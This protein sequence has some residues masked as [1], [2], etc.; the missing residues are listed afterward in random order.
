MTQPEVLTQWFFLPRTCT[1]YFDRARVVSTV[2][3]VCIFIV[4]CHNLWT[5]LSLLLKPLCAKPRSWHR[6]CRILWSSQT[7]GTVQSRMAYFGGFNTT[8]KPMAS[9][10]CTQWMQHY[11]YFEELLPFPSQPPSD[12][13]N[14]RINT[15]RFGFS[16][17]K[18]A[19]QVTS[20]LPCTCPRV[21]LGATN[22]FRMGITRGS[23]V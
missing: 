5:F 15:P 3:A 1:L 8:L 10:W 9:K 11:L 23:A 14:C 18:V 13:R 6:N 20:H 22:F 16:T 12:L 19:L 4:S 21:P 2:S 17:K 7:A